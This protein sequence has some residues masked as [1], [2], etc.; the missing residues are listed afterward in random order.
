MLV[1]IAICIMSFLLVLL[2]NKHALT[3]KLNYDCNIIAL[4]ISHDFL[5][6]QKKSP[7]KKSVDRIFWADFFKRV[8]YY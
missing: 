4:R 1:V 6:K 5:N 3:Y 7:L 8:A 2:A